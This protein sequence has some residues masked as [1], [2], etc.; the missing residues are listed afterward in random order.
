VIFTTFCGKNFNLSRQMILEAARFFESGVNCNGF[1][2]ARCACSNRLLIKTLGSELK[3]MLNK[4]PLA[5]ASG[6]VQKTK[7][8]SQI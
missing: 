6:F 7:G 8:F 4:L 1:F 2:L 5:S 3:I